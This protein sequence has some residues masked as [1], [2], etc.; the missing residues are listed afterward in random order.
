LLV[1]PKFFLFFLLPIL[2][3]IT[4]DGAV[5]NIVTLAIHVTLRP[6]YIKLNHNLYTVKTQM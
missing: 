6:K 3:P 1:S 5:M 2:D 4:Q